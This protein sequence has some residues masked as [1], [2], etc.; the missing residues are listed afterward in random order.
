M[1]ENIS[2]LKKFGVSVVLDDFGEGF[3]SFYDLQKYNI[4]G[5]KLDKGLVDQILTP[6]GKTILKY[7]VKVGHE[8]QITILAEGVENEEQVNV[9]QEIGC[10]VIQG[11]YFY[12]PMPDW[13]AKTKIL[14]QFSGCA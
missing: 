13:E 4:D 1:Q 12:Y 2:E 8:L 14:Q 9:L 10:D 11:Y 3:T 7:M 6:R 5:V